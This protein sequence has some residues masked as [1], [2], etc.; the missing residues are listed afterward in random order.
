MN[1]KKCAWPGC[2]S[3]VVETRFCGEHQLA[4]M[5][6]VRLIFST[7]A[8]YNL[9]PRDAIMAAIDL[10]PTITTKPTKYSQ[11]EVLGSVPNRSAVALFRRLGSSE[12]QSYNRAA[13][14]RRDGNVP[15]VSLVRAV[16]AERLWIPVSVAAERLGFPHRYLRHLIYEDGNESLMRLALTN[17]LVGRQVGFSRNTLT[18]LGTILEGVDKRRGR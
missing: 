9:T 7:C 3:S 15:T 13:K 8:R 11:Y 10:G 14:L 12:R 6:V 1:I 17:P 18:E 2:N 4:L 16:V 5:L